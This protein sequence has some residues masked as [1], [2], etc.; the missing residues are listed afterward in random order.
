MM[1]LLDCVTLP[2]P[3][4]RPQVKLERAVKPCQSFAVNEKNAAL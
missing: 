4:A 3:S 2:V 1:E